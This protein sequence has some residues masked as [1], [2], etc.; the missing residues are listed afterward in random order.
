MTK[1]MIKIIENLFDENF[2]DDFKKL[3]FFNEFKK[4][5]LKKCQELIDAG[6]DAEFVMSTFVS[7]M[8]ENLPQL[9][10]KNLNNTKIIDAIKK[11][12]ISFFDKL[13][14]CLLEEERYEDVIYIEKIRSTSI[15][16]NF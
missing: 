12:D 4:S 10:S 7:E 11:Q 15:I 6:Y 5:I 16:K 1:K 8:K 3:K 9:F 13:K 2:D 14:N